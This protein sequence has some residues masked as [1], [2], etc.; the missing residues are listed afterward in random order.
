[1]VK[2]VDE[3]VE[4]VQGFV[5]DGAH[6][7]PLPTSRDATTPARSHESHGTYAPLVTIDAGTTAGGF[8]GAGA[9]AGGA[10]AGGAGAGGAGGAGCTGAGAGCAG[11]GCDGALSCP[12]GVVGSDG[13]TG[14]LALGVGEGVAVL[15][16]FGVDEAVGDGVALGVVGDDPLGVGVTGA[17]VLFRATAVVMPSA[18]S[19]APAIADAMRM[20]LRRGRSVVVSV[21]VM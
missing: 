5:S 2:L 21:S 8:G 12:S 1:M 17:A 6:V 7:P 16:G 4:Y 11:A 9:G 3:S 15:V 18:T 20:R 14:S 10:G 13:A 19:N